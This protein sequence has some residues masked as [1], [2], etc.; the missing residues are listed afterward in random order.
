[1]PSIISKRVPFSGGNA[2][3]AD[4]QRED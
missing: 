4:D 1:L 3:S 2:E